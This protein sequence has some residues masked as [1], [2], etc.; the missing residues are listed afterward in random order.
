[1]P[2]GAVLDSGAWTSLN[3]QPNGN[4][5][6][7]GNVTAGK[8]LVDLNGADNVII[9][10]LNAG[11]NSLT[12]TNT[13][14]SDVIYTSTIRFINDAKNNTITN[15]TILGSSTV[16]GSTPGGTVLF[17][18]AAVNGTGNDGNT[19][20]SCTIGSAGSS[21]ASK[22][23]HSAG[24]SADVTPAFYN[25]DN[26]LLNNN[27]QDFFNPISL[28]NGVWLAEGTIQMTISGNRFFQ[29][30]PRVQTIGAYQSAIQ[31][32]HPNN[33][34]HIVSNNIIG[35][36]SAAGT[37]VY[38][39]TGQST[40]SGFITIRSSSHGT[41]NATSIE[42]NTIAG[43]SLNGVVG[44]T[45]AGSVFGGVNIGSGLFSIT[46]NMIGSA[47]V[48]NSIV[49]S[50]NTSAQVE[51][52][53][54]F[55]QPPLSVNVSNNIVGGIQ[56]S[57]GGSGSGWL[58]GMAISSAGTALHTI[59]DNVIGS[60]LAPLENYCAGTNSRTLGIFSQWGVVDLTDNVVSD[61]LMSGLN[62]LAGLGSCMVGISVQNTAT[63]NVPSQIVGNTVRR[64]TNTNTGAIN[65]AGI[66]YN[67]PSGINASIDRNL[68]HELYVGSWQGNV[69]GIGAYAGLATYSNNMVRLG[70]SSDLQP[71]ATGNFIQGLL[72]ASGD[73]AFYHNSVHLSGN[74]TLAV[75]E[76]YALYSAP[77]TGIRTYINNIL[78]N[79]CTNAGNGA[80]QYAIR[81]ATV[82]AQT[83]SDHNVLYAS[84][85]GGILARLNFTDLTTLD[86]WQ[87]FTGFDM[88][89]FQDAA[90]FVGPTSIPPDLHIQS[91]TIA[92]GTGTPVGI[93]YDHDGE[94]RSDLTPTD[95]GADA[96]D[97]V[98]PY[99]PC[100][101]TPFAGNISVQP[102]DCASGHISIVL[103]NADYGDGITYSWY[104]SS[105]PDGPFNTVPDQNNVVYVLNDVQ[106]TTYFKV[107][108]TCTHIGL[109]SETAVLMVAP[110][111]VHATYTIDNTQPTG[112]TNYNTFT[113]AIN[114]LNTLT[115]FGEI[116]FNV[117]ADVVFHEDPPAI[118]AEA[119]SNLPVIFQRSGVGA[120]P[121]LHPTGTAGAFDAGFR[122]FGGDNIIFDGIDVDVM[123]GADVEFGYHIRNLTATEGSVSNIIKNGK[124]TMNRT[125]PNSLG[126]LCSSSN[127]YGGEAPTE[128]GG[129]NHFNS[130]VNMF[131]TNAAKGINIVSSSQALKGI[132][133]SVIGC[134]IGADYAG[135]PAGDIPSSSSFGIAFAN[136]VSS[137]IRSN[138]VRN[139]AFAGIN[140]GIWCSNMGDI[141]EISANRIHGIRNTG[142]TTQAQHG[143]ELSGHGGVLFKVRNN[144]ISD[145]TTAYAGTAT[146]NRLIRGI[147]VTNSTSDVFL[148]VDFNNIHIDGSGAP[149]ASNACIDIAYALTQTVMRNN[150]LVNSTSSQTT[151]KHYIYKSTSFNLFS[152][153][154]AFHVPNGTGGY[155]FATD[156]EYPTLAQWQQSTNDDLNSMMIDPMFQDP[157][158]DLHVNAVPLI[159]AGMEIGEIMIDIDGEER[160]TPP[161]IGADEF[162]APDPYVTL[163][164]KV[165][166]DGAYVSSTGLMRDDLRMSPEFPL[167]QPFDIGPWF[168]NG[169]ESIDPSILPGTGATQAVVDWVLIEI[170][171]KNSPATLIARRAAML[172]RDGDVVDLDGASALEFDLVPPGEYYVSIRHRNHLGV[173][174]NAP[175]WLANAPINIDLTNSS[176]AVHGTNPRKAIG[177]VMTLWGGNA[178]S[179]STV[180]YSGSNNDRASVLSFLGASSFLVP[181]SGYYAADVNMNGSVSYSGSNNDRTFIL[182]TLGAT[183]FLTPLT[184]QVP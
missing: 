144:F 152:D 52:Y 179:N 75:R 64:L 182:N 115:C 183:S 156:Q 34:G 106:D 95:I 11:G 15:C 67:G 105:S 22:A 71:S 84:G 154:N 107:R 117:K 126:I 80:G 26:Q 135:V 101:G 21:L 121:I 123:G 38:T 143:M 50:T 134:T 145:I 86:Q 20:S 31:F 91:P 39:F 28:S 85:T 36:A 181:V 138:V 92:D 133:N 93:I 163:T 79:Q 157:Q 5:T 114:W 37:G 124:V 61:L 51:A 73:C 17:S 97:H 99:V 65:V 81:I 141:I 88:N 23:I 136:Q 7:S 55:H 177:N 44:G 57:N 112:S 42:N 14:V 87:A 47:T 153:H 24:S 98:N 78:E 174:T 70:V 27:I 139:V 4:V 8:P 120:N 180:S 60:E 53:G 13:T 111:L 103:E 109:Y 137:V 104:S 19:I 63:M 128:I 142:N 148:E 149:N 9:N 18:T 168:Y 110:Q 150:V 41:T 29:T 10:G 2:D 171:D 69:L 90:N 178:N 43:I 48:E 160:P 161:T 176:T 56:L 83:T 169:T 89:S 68:V 16:T 125:N 166:L 66:H 6:V 140:R 74:T 33:G 119:T 3:I 170:R 122:V 102:V 158:K 159:G 184:E 146:L 131:V 173:R 118:T 164:M 94:T 72:H 147:S 82:D 175:V 35:F 108:V 77:T 167:D 54:I 129:V 30:A 40:N 172:Q 100:S 155:L 59:K 96:G 130:I 12:F 62:T 151:A 49:I 127:L 45:G 25:S 132:E 116:I 165:F 162:V 1:L 113:E 32:A 76:T 46:G 58:M